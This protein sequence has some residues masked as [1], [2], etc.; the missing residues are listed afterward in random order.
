M[1]ELFNK[2]KKVFADLA[3][4]KRVANKQ[5]F[6]M[7]PRYVVEY[8]ASKFTDKYGEENYGPQLSKFIAKYY[9]E[10][11]ERD[12]VLSDV[13]T[14][15]KITLIDEV[16]VTTDVELGTYRAHLQ[17]LNLKDCM[18]NLDVLDKNQNLL[19]AG[20][21]GLVTLSYSPDTAPETM[22]PILIDGFDPFQC[23]T[24]DTKI[25]QEARESFTFEEWIDII[26]NTV[27]LNHERYNLR[28]KL[29]FL[30]RLIPLVEN[31]TNLMEFG[32]KQTGK[33]Y[34]YRNSSY[35]TRIFAGGNISA[36]TL[37]YN[38]ARRELGEMAAKDA[39]ILDEI[40][41]VKFT[42][43][44]EMIGKLKDYMESGHYERGPKRAASTCA[45]M[46]MGNI[47]VEQ[48]ETG[49]VPVEDFTY[50]LPKDMRDSALIDRIHGVLPGWELPKISMSTRHLSRGY[51][52][53]SDYFCEIMHE[54]RKQNYTHIIDQEI[55]L[56]GDYTIRDE[57]AVKR[58]ASGLLKLLIPNAEFDSTELK[59]IMDLAIEYRN[60]VNDWLH[61][62][63]P[64]EFA[65][66][67]LTY[68]PRAGK[69][70]TET[71]P[72][73]EQPGLIRPD[74][75][76]K[77]RMEYQR[78]IAQCDEFI[79]WIDKYFSKV[80]LEYILDSVNPLSVKEIKILTSIKNADEKFRKLFKE[81]AESMKTRGATAE[82]RVLDP[83]TEKELHDRWVL[84]KHK[85]FNIPS[86]DIVARGQYSEIKETP[87]KPPFAELWKTAKDI[88]QEWNTIIKL[89]TEMESNQ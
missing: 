79:Y 38:I 73:E 33:T 18:I 27:G 36:A 86:P 84:S 83:K 68:S 13:M 80:G 8:L 62:I 25:I 74:D 50:V 34:L 72:I 42:N 59:I 22:A 61:I 89:K 71:L 78:M 9:H 66:K 24:T 45:L 29:I 56:T 51:G 70:S 43:P 52:I 4:D 55:N 60:R 37:F 69:I 58:I 65:K 6:F 53:A 17:N 39:I 1:S 67:N 81:F 20:M 49:Y 40:S 10:A 23:T 77:N 64:G 7:L 30:T 31:N 19:M 47:T 85:N 75:P 3:T 35:Y 16:K 11:R 48:K 26:L 46:L 76:F 57:K 5:E 87:N 63:S 44:D 54:L 12:K 2:T 28:Q 15:G 88:I 41:K 14:T 21:W 32:P 82:L